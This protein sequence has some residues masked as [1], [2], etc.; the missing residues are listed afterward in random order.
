MKSI[1]LH[2]YYS[3]QLLILLKYTLCM[4]P[5]FICNHKQFVRRYSE[6]FGFILM[7]LLD[8]TKWRTL[9]SMYLVILTISLISRL[10]GRKEMH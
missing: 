8:E 4:L 7:A 3:V 1:Y 5:E 6:T 10:R 9:K 2:N